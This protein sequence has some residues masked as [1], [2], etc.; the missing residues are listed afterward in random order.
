MAAP[1]AAADSGTSGTSNLP[2]CLLVLG[3]AGSGKTT[4]E[5]LTTEPHSQRTPP[6]FNI[7]FL[8]VVGHNTFILFYFFSF[9]CSAED[10]PQGLAHAT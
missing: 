7:Y 10:Q 1:V 2:V 4:F 5:H 8:V 6:H 3:M 9:L